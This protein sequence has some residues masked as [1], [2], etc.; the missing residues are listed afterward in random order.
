MLCPLHHAIDFSLRR[1][2][3]SGNGELPGLLCGLSAALMLRMS[4][5]R[6]R[7]VHYLRHDSW[8]RWGCHAISTPMGKES[9]PIQQVLH[10]EGPS[11]CGCILH[12]SSV[13]CCFIR[14][15]D[16]FDALSLKNSASWR[17]LRDSGRASHKC[18]VMHVSF[19]DALLSQALFTK[20]IGLRSGQCIPPR[21][22]SRNEHE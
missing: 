10:C 9:R 13:F 7:S 16:V 14:V 1:A 12:C 11:L 4:C 22:C 15:M 8:S 17:Y 21:S 3:F 18:Q 19:H 20:P 2:A 5:H 6:F